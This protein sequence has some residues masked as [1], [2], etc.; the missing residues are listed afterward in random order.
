MNREIST[1]KTRITTMVYEAFY[2]SLIDIEYVFENLK[3]DDTVLGLK[4]MNKFKGAVKQ[5]NAFF[6]SITVILYLKKFDKT[7]NLKVFLNGKVQ[8]SGVKNDD[9]VQYAMELFRDKI[10]DIHGKKTI[11]VVNYN[12]ILYDKNEY[13]LNIDK[14]HTRFNAIKIYGKSDDSYKIIGERKGSDFVIFMNGSRE[15]VIEFGDYFL[16][17]KK[18]PNHVKILFDKN[19]NNIGTVK[20]VFRRIR[21]NITIKGIRFIDDDTIDI[22]C[23]EDV[24]TIKDCSKTVSM[25]DRFDN[26]IGKQIVLL[27]HGSKPVISDESIKNVTINYTSICSNSKLGSGTSDFK[28][29]PFNI[30]CDFNIL[31]SGDDNMSINLYRM[32][33]FLINEYGINAYY[34]PTLK[35]PALNIKLYLEKNENGNDGCDDDGEYT[36]IL[37][38]K[39]FGSK[40]DHRPPS[41]YSLKASIRVFNSNKA[42]IHGCTCNSQIVTVKKILCDLL[43]KHS[44]VFF[45]YQNN[46]KS[47]IIDENISIYDII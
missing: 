4:F 25:Y 21:K 2:E 14:P 31:S 15:N 42:S 36:Q 39:L 47:T 17:I 7:V 32:Y 18:T 13:D 35:D 45:D 12:G 1:S 23:I 11:D 44:N 29:R 10:V 43:N 38:N 28:M 22:K 33:N 34:N 40:K 27:L 19:G 30:N 8:L 3:I 16:Q 9:H 41:E 6:N 5:T 20:Y 24:S 26:F 37:N 46:K